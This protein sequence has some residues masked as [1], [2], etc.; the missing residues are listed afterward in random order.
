[1][2]PD[3]LSARGLFV[4]RTTRRTT[5]APLDSPDGGEVVVLGFIVSAG[6]PPLVRLERQR[7]HGGTP[8][9]ALGFYRGCAFVISPWRCSYGAPKPSPTVRVVDLRAILEVP[10]GDR[11]EREDRLELLAHAFDVP[12]ELSPIVEPSVSLVDDMTDGPLEGIVLKDRSWYEREAWRFD[13][14]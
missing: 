10:P 8:S 5:F 2:T 7:R 6:V 1:M 13:R 3:G 14:R 11:F 9:F 12:L 4:A